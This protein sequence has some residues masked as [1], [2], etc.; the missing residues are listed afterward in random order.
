ME[1]REREKN[2]F[3][4]VHINGHMKLI[5]ALLGLIKKVFHISG[6]NLVGA[7]TARQST[8]FAWHFF[9]QKFSLW[10]STTFIFSPSTVEK[11]RLL[12]SF[13]VRGL[14]GILIIAKIKPSFQWSSFIMASPYWIQLFF[15]PFSL[16]QSR[17]DVETLQN[18]VSQAG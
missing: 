2:Q 6:K 3:T 16:K 14:Q 4:Y 12:L 18:Y 7:I 15:C 11:I 8:F 5:E 17:T 10:D 9:T 13:W 1:E